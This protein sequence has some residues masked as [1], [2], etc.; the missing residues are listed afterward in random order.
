MIQYPCGCLNEVHTL[1]GAMFCAGKCEFH[2][3]ELAKQPKG[4]DY[5]HGLG[6]IDAEGKPRTSHYFREFWDAIGPFP[7][8]EVVVEIGGGASPYVQEL[9]A[10]GYKQYVG[11]DPDEWA[12][13]WMRKTYGVE[14]LRSLFP[15]PA[16][17]GELPEADMVLCTHALERMYDAVEG[18]SQM[19]RLLTPGGFLAVLVPDDTDPVN[20]DHRWF[21]NERSLRKA[22]ELVGFASDSIAVVYRKVVEKE[23]FLYCVARKA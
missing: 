4:F 17:M 2:R 21:F 5:Y 7:T 1:T 10:A 18:L 12:C 14:M 15:I 9:R 13:E 16:G 19:H 23:G 6:T 8:G 3:A 11:V 20:P 22:V